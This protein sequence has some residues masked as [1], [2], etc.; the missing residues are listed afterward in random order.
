M[1]RIVNKM[2]RNAFMTI[3]LLGRPLVALLV[4]EEYAHEFSET[5]E[6]RNERAVNPRRTMKPPEEQ[7]GHE[8]MGRVL[9]RA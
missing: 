6:S 7:E 4:T 8:T 2:L 3:L 1:V 9:N 5:I